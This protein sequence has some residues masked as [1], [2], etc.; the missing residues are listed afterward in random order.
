MTH[1]KKKYIY[2][3]THSIYKI[4]VSQI[5]KNSFYYIQYIMIFFCYFLKNTGSSLK[6]EFVDP[7]W[8][9][10]HNLKNTDCLEN[11]FN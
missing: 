7:K 9:V 3:E 5:V 6:N 8:V 1:G 11:K 2:T 10:T 4:K